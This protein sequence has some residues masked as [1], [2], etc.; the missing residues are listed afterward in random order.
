[1]TSKSVTGVAGIM[2]GFNRTGL[3][4]IGSTSA[5]TDS[6]SSVMQKTTNTNQTMGEAV[7]QLK[8]PS[9]TGTSDSMIKKETSKAAQKLK[10]KTNDSVGTQKDEEALQ[11][12]ADAVEEAAEKVVKEVADALDV[13]EEEVE[14]A[15]EALGLTAVSL[16]DQTK[17]TQL[18]M[19]LSGETDVFALTTNEELYANIME[20]VSMVSDE[21]AAVKEA[22]GLNDMQMQECIEQLAQREAAGGAVEGMEEIT[23]VLEGAG[24]EETVEQKERPEKAVVTITKNGEEIKAVVET[25]AK[26]GAAAITQE[27]SPL[28]ERNAGEDMMQN[29]GKEGQNEQGGKDMQSSNLVLQNIA[30]GQETPQVQANAELPLAD[31]QVRDLMDQIMDYMKVQVKADTTS[32][33]MQLHPESLGTLNI[34]IAAKD[35]IL[36]AQFTAQNEAVKNAIEGQ[37]ASLQQ[38]L[39]DQGIKV[40][41]VEV[42]VAAQHFDRNMEQGQNGNGSSSEEAKKKNIRRINLRDLESAEEEE[43]E[44]A[45]K[46]A[47][48][49]MARNG[50][51][52]DYLA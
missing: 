6:F 13:S 19:N 51:S 24:G 9:K 2:D 4:S 18:M 42:N 35:G 29:D 14:A 40:E 37:L 43:L 12:A 1:M 16:L 5:L 7:M 25:D 50:N 8:E 22:F 34:H 28:T 27:S 33:E 48:D 30:Q 15:M 26:T 20:T 38:S 47:V 10:E 31:A 45:E 21:L 52:V 11:N 41:A 44:E 32:L 17:L 49:M 36:T 3:N 39:N 46:L 23:P